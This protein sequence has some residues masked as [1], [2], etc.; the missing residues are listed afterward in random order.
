MRTPAVFALALLL[1]ACGS[2]ED[3][4]KTMCNSR[5]LAGAVSQTMSPVER[6]TKQADYIDKHLGSKQGRALFE[7]A[8]RSPDKW[9]VIGD[10][11]KKAGIP[12]P[13]A[14]PKNPLSG[15]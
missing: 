10:A 7:E 1:A 8:G 2:Y 12:C 5:E 4:L 6:A 3:D 15:S 9:K 14:Q 13:D 11:A